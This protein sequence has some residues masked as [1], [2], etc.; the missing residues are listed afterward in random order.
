MTGDLQQELSVPSFMQQYTIGW[1]LD[2]QA[3]KNK[4]P[5]GEAETLVGG[6]SL[7]ADALN[8]LGLTE[9]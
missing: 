4:G 3:A 5:G 8:G 1:P 9:F 7:Q 2:R 6:I